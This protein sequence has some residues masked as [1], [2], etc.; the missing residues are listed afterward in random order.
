MK[1]RLCRSILAMTICLLFSSPSCSQSQKYT[2][3][4]LPSGRIVKIAGVGKICFSNDDPALMLKY[5]TDVPITDTGALREEVEDIWQSFKFDVEQSGLKS[6]IISA[7][8]MSTGII[9]KTKG[10]NFVF[11]TQGDGSWAM[12][13]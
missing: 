2:P 10:F 7:N 1:K 3:K 13:K 11:K 6:A 8:E 5:Y 12:L 4:K 9:S